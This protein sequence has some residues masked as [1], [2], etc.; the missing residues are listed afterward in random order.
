MVESGRGDE[1]NA[2]DSLRLMRSFRSVSHRA[3]MASA[4]FS[5]W[6]RNYD[7]SYVVGWGRVYLD[8]EAYANAGVAANAALALPSGIVR[9]AALASVIGTVVSRDDALAERLF[10]ELGSTPYRAWSAAR[11]Y[12]HFAD[13]ADSGRYRSILEAE[14]QL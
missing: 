14:C 6:S 3:R 7:L 8:D 1:W 2:E 10:E 13:K 5:R 12:T 11:L 4:V 9:D